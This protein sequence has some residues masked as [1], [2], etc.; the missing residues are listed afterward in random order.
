MDRVTA[1]SRDYI[2]TCR[3]HIARQLEAYR[4]LAASANRRA[5]ADFE[6]LF[7]NHLLLALDHYFCHRC[8]AVEGTDG[9]AL[10]EMR[11]LCTSIVENRSVL[12]DEP[13]SAPTVTPVLKLRPG[14]S[15][16]LNE[17]QFAAISIAFFS[18]IERRFRAPEPDPEPSEQVDPSQG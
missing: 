9:N 10:Q 12:L 18:E 16:A 4:T 6:P 13:G 2:D 14:S 11:L 17:E 15:I 1:Y 8:P 3:L 5:V 7:L